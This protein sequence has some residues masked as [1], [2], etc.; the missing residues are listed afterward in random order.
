MV[1][2]PVMRNKEGEVK[3]N[4]DAELVLQAMVD[5]NDYNKAMIITGDGDFHCLVSYFYRKDKLLSVL[6]PNKD[7]SSVL[8]RKAA[9]E[10]ISFLNNLQKKLEYRK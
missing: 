5:F 6:S 8:L 9:K 10:K 1:F 7:K 2:K 3:G 4:V